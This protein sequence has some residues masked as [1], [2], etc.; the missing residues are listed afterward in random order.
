MDQQVG[1]PDPV[2]LRD[3]SSHIRDLI[4]SDPLPDLCPDY[5]DVVAGF[6]KKDPRPNLWQPFSIRSGHIIHYNRDWFVS[7]PGQRGRIRLYWNPSL[8]GNSD[9]VG[10]KDRDT[11]RFDIASAD[12]VKIKILFYGLFS[13]TTPRLDLIDKSVR[14]DQLFRQ[15]GLHRMNPARSVPLRSTPLARLVKLY[16]T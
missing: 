4:R 10:P 16:A 3:I 1:L 15:H 6:P 13:R 7:E 5:G 11:I 9:T 8:A 2:G 14:Q 12:L